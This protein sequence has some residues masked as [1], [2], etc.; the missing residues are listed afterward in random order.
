MENAALPDFVRMKENLRAHYYAVGLQNN[1][2]Y[3]DMFSQV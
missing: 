1:S 2:T 3:T